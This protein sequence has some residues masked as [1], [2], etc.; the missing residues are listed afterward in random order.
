MPYRTSFNS[1]L[2]MQ[3][4]SLAAVDNVRS[5]PIGTIIRGFDDVLN[6]EGD[7]IYFPGVANLVAGDVVAY[8]ML[9]SG[10]FVTRIT[11]A[12]N[13]SGHPVAVALTAI[14]LGSFGWYQIGGVAVVNVTAASAVGRMFLT[15]TAGQVNSAAVA[16]SQVIGARLSTAI[17]T[18]AAGQAYVTLTRPSVQTQIT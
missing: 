12:F 7:F 3:A 16:G 2:G 4:F 18:P 5:H 6:V 14:P 17:G 1:G 10:A 13:N 8:D 11:T 15:A 9:P